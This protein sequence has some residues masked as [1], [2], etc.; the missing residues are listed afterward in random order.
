MADER[1]QQMPFSY[2][3]RLDTS[4]TASTAKGMYDL[5]IYNGERIS[6]HHGPRPR[7]RVRTGSL[8]Y[9]ALHRGFIV[10]KYNW[11]TAVSVPRMVMENRPVDPGSIQGSHRPISFIRRKH[12]TH[13]NYIVCKTEY[14]GGL[15]VVPVCAR[16][17]HRYYS[18]KCQN[19]C[20]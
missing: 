2:S 19:R 12:R 9:P 16:Q 3:I 18:E 6:H 14:S 13:A 17:G 15:P 10:R 11:Y 7:Q 5:T 4:D 20:N 1:S 8:K